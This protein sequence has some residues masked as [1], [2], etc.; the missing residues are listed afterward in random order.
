MSYITSNVLSNG[1]AGEGVE[2][3]GLP[4][5]SASRRDY[6]RHRNFLDRWGIRY[7]VITRTVETVTDSGTAT[8]TETVVL[9]KPS[10][11]WLADMLRFIAPARESLASNGAARYYSEPCE[12]YSAG[13]SGYVAVPVAHTETYCID[14][15]G[16]S[17]ARLAVIETAAGV[18]TV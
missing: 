11:I 17:P 3:Y 5:D 14:I 15:A 2:F 8:E 7:A 1:S 16:V 12:Y 13:V 6:G 4:D 9:S 18:R 10:P